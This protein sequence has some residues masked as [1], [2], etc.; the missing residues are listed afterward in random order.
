MILRWVCRSTGSTA[1]SV[2]KCPRQ[3]VA[4]F[5]ISSAAKLSGQVSRSL[6]RTFLII[7][8][9]NNNKVQRLPINRVL[10]AK[11]RLVRAVLWH[12]PAVL[13]PTASVSS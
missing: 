10:G 4:Y 13:N 7:E 9:P 5:Y 12:V 6:K 8:T 11:Y 3:C 1:Y 2:L